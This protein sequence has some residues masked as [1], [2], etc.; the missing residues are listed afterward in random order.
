M[1]GGS[2]SDWFDDVWPDRGSRPVLR[3]RRLWR[4]LWAMV[5]LLG[6]AA[7]CGAL[8]QRRMV[9]L[10]ERRY[11]PLGTLVDVGG[12]RL[13]LYC[14][15]RGRP[16]VILEAGLPG[17][18]LDWALVQPKL[19]MST[20]VCAY[21]RAGYGWSELGPRPRISLRITDELHSLLGRAGV[22]G[23]YVLVGHSFGGLHVRLYASRFPT[24]VAGVV[25]VDAPAEEVVRRRPPPVVKL[26]W[27]EAKIRLGLERLELA[28]G[29][30][31]DAPKLPLTVRQAAA[32]RTMRPA[33]CRAAYD[34]ASG[35]A[36][37]LWEVRQAAD[38]GSKPL[39]VVTRGRELNPQ[40]RAGQA[41]LLRLSTSSSQVV[42]A[43]SGHYVQLDR[44]DVVVAA[45]R[46]VLAAAQDAAGCTDHRRCQGSVAVS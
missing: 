30:D 27:C 8:Y 31:R 18:S 26:L 37:S 45:V 43:G 3:R 34:E 20:R 9:R 16:T 5:A 42:A 36:E 33:T 38:L 29:L 19:A 35:R 32:A 25:L 11:P 7:A 14:T 24:Q 17:S 39:M 2:K 10:E 21:D 15:G 28:L 44:P 46:T 6:L 41:A 40:W 4:S 13:H 22:S 12:H 23:P 1:A